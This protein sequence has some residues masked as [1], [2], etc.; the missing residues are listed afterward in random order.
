MHSY[1]KSLLISI[2][3]SI[4]QLF[5]YLI[6]LSGFQMQ[7][8]SNPPTSCVLKY[9]AKN[10]PFFVFLLNKWM[11]HSSEENWVHFSFFFQFFR[12]QGKR[13]THKVP[14]EIKK[15]RGKKLT[16]YVQKVLEQIQSQ[17]PDNVER[18]SCQLEF[19]ANI[20]N[21]RNPADNSHWLCLE[22]ED[23][24]EWAM[25]IPSFI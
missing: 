15:E 6:H 2:D 18:P 8:N 1:E 22:E 21:R 19:R 3:I 4:I 16:F 23:N 13:E 9:C 17:N 10:I 5:F 7:R 25:S 11:I 12:P 24:C 14:T 20:S